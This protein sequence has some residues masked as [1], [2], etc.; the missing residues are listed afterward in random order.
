M[1]NARMPELLSPV[2]SVVNLFALMLVILLGLDFL[3]F[4]YDAAK[5]CGSNGYWPLLVAF[6]LV[7]LP[8]ALL[9]HLM[10]RRFPNQDLMAVA[11]QA[12]GK[13]LAWIGNLIF[14]SCFVIWLVMAIR[15]SG[16]LVLIYFLNRTPVWAVISLFLI[17]VG[18]VAING[19]APALRLAA[20][21]L[22]PTIFFRFLMQL[23]ALQGLKVT[24]LL[25]LFALPPLDYFRGGLALA[26]VF[27][28]MTA[29]FLIHPL[30]KKPDK[31]GIPALCAAAIASCSFFLGIIG[32]IGV[33]G[34]ELTQR[35]AWSEFATVQ[36]INITYLVLEQVG[37]LFLVIWI[38]MFFVSTSFYF[39][40]VARSLQQ[41]FPVLNYR[42]T[43]VGLLILVLIG[44]LSFPNGLIA[45]SVFTVLRRWL[46][47]PAGVYP[48]IVYTVAVIRGKR[49]IR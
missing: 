25:P 21:I 6:C 29:I 24:N 28:P 11:T 3:D 22:I 12:L 17:G 41:Q 10:H 36:Q 32:A 8:L 7:A 37:L 47:L 4:P 34:A 49:G 31:L 48:L 2:T 42:W 40:I 20:F 33:F 38:S 15:D 43:V 9:L 19:L 23:F 39:A 46:I 5:I 18:Y 35:Y 26:N 27:M 14:L 13:P 1:K 44:I 30:L 16:E 45:H